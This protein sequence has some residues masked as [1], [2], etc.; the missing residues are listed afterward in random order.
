MWNPETS[1]VYT[2]RDITWLNRFFYT[3]PIADDDTDDF[4]QIVATD[5]VNDAA[6][7][8]SDATADNVPA[9]SRTVRFE[10]QRVEDERGER[11]STQTKYNKDRYEAG[12]SGMEPYVIWN[13][14]KENDGGP[15]PNNQ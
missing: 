12:T 8:E 7:G 11:R 4:F 13:D 9:A 14:A 2:T 15:E 3:K 6:K 10:E 5:K 1:W